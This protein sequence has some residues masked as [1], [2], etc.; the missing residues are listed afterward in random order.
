MAHF[1]GLGPTHRPIWRN[2]KTANNIRGADRDPIS[3]RC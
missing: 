1:N 3:R 2:S